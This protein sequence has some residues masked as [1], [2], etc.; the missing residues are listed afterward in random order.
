MT[1][2]STVD[3]R[4]QS[5]NS[6]QLLVRVFTSHPSD[7]RVQQPM[8][9]LQ[10]NYEKLCSSCGAN[11]ASVFCCAFISVLFQSSFCNSRGRRP[12]VQRQAHNGLLSLPLSAAGAV[13]IHGYLCVCAQMRSEIIACEYFWCLLEGWPTT[14]WRNCKMKVEERDRQRGSMIMSNNFWVYL[15]EGMR[16]RQKTKVKIL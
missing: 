12:G 14:S 10:N 11:N 8:N 2:A 4:G 6:S 16:K 13:K 15:K 7:S 5:T 1:G 3:R 9:L